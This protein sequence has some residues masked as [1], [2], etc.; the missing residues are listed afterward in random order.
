M[1]LSIDMVEKTFV[2]GDSFSSVQFISTLCDIKRQQMWY[3]EFVENELVDRTKAGQSPFTMFLQATHDAI[4]ETSGVRMIIA[5]GA[6]HRLPTYTDGWYG[7]EQLKPV[8]PT[9]P[10]P[11]PARPTTLSDC[12]KYLGRAS[13]TKENL[14]QFHPT[15]MWA[16]IYKGIVDL[17]LRCAQQ[18]HQLLVL[19][20]NTTPTTPWINK[21]H[22]LI[23]PLCQH[24]ES[25]RN[26]ITEADSCCQVCQRSAVR[27]ADY[28]SY[29]WQGHHGPEGQAYFGKHIQQIVAQRQLWN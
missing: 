2:Y 23:A 14:L 22:P 21:S 24:A 5:L 10:L 15:L 13:M 20:M 26:Y 3:H 11:A 8:D 19:H 25:M 7:E 4:T 16:M 1:A 28:D 17:G 6:C 27:P 12:E 9:T 18:G 29:G